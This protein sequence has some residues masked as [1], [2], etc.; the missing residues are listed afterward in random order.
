MTRLHSIA[1]IASRT[2][3]L[4]GLIVAL[5]L[6]SPAY[7]ALA[8]VTINV[9]TFSDVIAN[10]GVCSLREAI[11]AANTNTASGAAAGECP[12]GTTGTDTILLPAGTYTLGIAGAGENANATGDLDITNKTV[13]RGLG[14]ADGTIIDGASLDRVFHVQTSNAV[15]SLQH[16]SITHGRSP[17]GANATASANPAPGQNGGGIFLDVLAQLAITAVRVTDSRAGDG[18]DGFPDTTHNWGHNGGYGGGVF[19]SSSSYF[20]MTDSAVRGNGAGDAGIG[21]GTSGTCS[22]GNGGRG[23]GLYVDLTGRATVNGS[24]IAGN[25]GGNGGARGGPSCGPD[26]YGG[27][28]GGAFSIGFLTLNN[29]TVSTNRTGNGGGTTANPGLGGG[30]AQTTNG[31]LTLNGAT[32]SGNSTSN[33]PFAASGGGIYFSPS[34]TAT[35]KNS[36]IAGNTNPGG[37]TPDCFTSLPINSQDYN[38]LGV[39]N[40][41]CQ[42][43]GVRTHVISNTNALLLS[44][45]Y[46]GGPGLTHALHPSSP[47]KDWIPNGTN[48]CGAAPLNLDQRGQPRPANASC[49]MGAFELQAS[50]TITQRTGLA[51]GVS[52]TFTGTDVAVVNTAASTYTGT[53]TVDKHDATPPNVNLFNLAA[54][55][56]YW[57]VGAQPWAYDLTCLLRLLAGPARQHLGVKPARLPLGWRAGGLG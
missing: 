28:G 30:V 26:G 53:V 47:A 46:G 8:D 56:V 43:T 11:T 49:D 50:E 38:L 55:P 41:N 16:L 7:V 45:A 22:G 35:V 27:S 39:F 15:V 42:M 44:L 34:A 1:A 32:I 13:I 57:N 37:S 10:D 14:G 25:R 21:V 29:S 9:S 5:S 18:G 40:A 31:A 4:L 48:G 19:V 2:L 20:T 52:T 54:L 17:D 51:T 3:A 36:V 6:F 23:G 12:A 33:V 24:T